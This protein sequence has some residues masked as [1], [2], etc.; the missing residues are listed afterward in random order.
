[1][2]LLTLHVINNIDMNRKKLHFWPLIG[3]VATTGNGCFKG[4]LADAAELSF[5]SS[6][7]EGLRKS[8]RTTTQPHPDF[9]L[10]LTTAP[11]NWYFTTIT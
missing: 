4:S 8:S 3:S 1:M 6:L 9:R 11:T 10:W 7:A 2:Y 5:V